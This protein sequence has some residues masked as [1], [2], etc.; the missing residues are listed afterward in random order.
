[1]LRAAWMV[2]EVAPGGWGGPFA[3]AADFAP[4]DLDGATD[5]R[6]A[7]VRGGMYLRWQSDAAPGTVY[8]VYLDGRLAWEGPQKAVMLPVGG[9]GGRRVRVAVGTVGRRNVGVDYS[10]RLDLPPDRARLSWQGGRYLGPAL[11]GY[12]IYAG[13][14]PGSAV[15]MTNRVGSILA[16]PG[17]FWKDGWGRGG[18]GQGGWGHAA[19]TYA[20]TSGALGSGTWHFA[21]ATYDTTGAENPSPILLSQTIAAPPGQPP[22]RAS[23]GKR[24]WV[25]SFDPA[26]GHYT[27]GWTLP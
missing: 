26:T 20:W 2:P 7:P 22:V 11:A 6:T 21:I 18:W 27:L 3:A 19:I 1:M 14:T 8:Q 10:D 12:R 15:D 24:L 17:G 23:D 16:S 5:L 9:P 25:T 4:L 13:R